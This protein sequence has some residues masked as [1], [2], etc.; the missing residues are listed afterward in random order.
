MFSLVHPSD[1]IHARARRMAAYRIVFAYVTSV[2]VDPVAAVFFLWC[3]RSPVLP[4]PYCALFLACPDL[5]SPTA[6]PTAPS[7]PQRNLRD[8]LT[9]SPTPQTA[10]RPAMPPR[11]AP[12]SD[13]RDISSIALPS[14]DMDEEPADEWALAYGEA[15]QAKFRSDGSPQGV[16]AA[17]QR[18][19]D[20]ILPHLKGEKKDEVREWRQQHDQ[21]VIDVEGAMQSWDDCTLSQLLNAIARL[22]AKD[23]RDQTVLD[24]LDELGDLWD[25]K[26]KHTLT[27]HNKTFLRAARM[28]KQMSM[29]AYTV[30]QAY[31]ESLPG[32]AKGARYSIQDEVQKVW[33]EPAYSTLKDLMDKTTKIYDSAVRKQSSLLDSIIGSS[34]DDEEPQRSDPK[35]KG[36]GAKKTAGAIALVPEQQPVTKQELTT[37]LADF[38][39][40]VENNVQ[41][42]VATALKEYG[43]KTEATLQETS[44]QLKEQAKVLH[45][46]AQLVQQL[47]ARKDDNRYD[48]YQNNARRDDNRYDRYQNDRRSGNKGGKG[49]GKGTFRGTCW[50][51]GR[52]GHRAADCPAKPKR[53]IFDYA[54][55]VASGEA[56]MDDEATEQLGADWDARRYYE[57]AIASQGKRNMSWWEKHQQDEGMHNVSRSC[58]SSVVVDSSGKSS[59]GKSSVKVPA[60]DEAEAGMC[61]GVSVDHNAITLIKTPCQIGAED[62]SHRPESDATMENFDAH[63]PNCDS[64]VKKASTCSSNI[65]VIDC[66]SSAATPPVDASRPVLNNAASVAGGSGLR[67]ESNR[68]FDSPYHHTMQCLQSVSQWWYRGNGSLVMA[69]TVWWL[70]IMGVLSTSVLVMYSCL[71]ASALAPT[72][73]TVTAPHT[74]PGQYQAVNHTGLP[75]VNTRYVWTWFMVLIYPQQ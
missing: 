42:Q 46:T 50:N 14:I 33:E 10:P 69:S 25:R 40:Q 54:N 35:Q 21:D 36:K 27:K 60:S 2:Y 17:E 71:N 62:T 37:I 22:A 9:Y 3:L 43:E 32:K 12:T 30:R 70:V 29:D 45:D 18:A 11:T 51:C 1:L 31:V 26:Q 16:L 20:S 23:I 74:I 44:K 61:S 55:A 39:T 52:E 57:A 5:R 63:V 72:V 38:K 75:A 41:G 58:A 8:R 19:K 53:P 7:T 73:S 65:P 48:R 13:I 6:T 59:V 68:V 67:Q 66:N 47:A 15:S 49:G 34:D 24:K 4:A 56:S 28:L 64:G